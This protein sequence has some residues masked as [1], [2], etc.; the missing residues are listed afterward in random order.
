MTTRSRVGFT[1]IELLVVI[2]IIAILA[3]ILF[4]VFAQAREKA[5]AIACLSNTK[6]L[7]LAFVQYTQDWDEY[8][9]DVDKTPSY[10][11]LDGKLAFPPW[12]VQ[13]MPYV[14]SWQVFMCPDRSDLMNQASILKT[15]QVK[16][17]NG[18]DPYDCWD[19][20]NPTGECVGYGYNDGWVTDGGYGML[21]TQINDV[22][23]NTLRDGRNIAQIVSPASM[24]AFGDMKTK[25]DGSVGCDAALTWAYKGG[26]SGPQG[27]RPYPTSL[28]RHDAF[29]NF[30]FADGHA[31]S[32]KM[33]AA[34]ETSGYFSLANGGNTL[35]I[36]A[37]PQ[38]A[39]DWCF[40]PNFVANYNDPSIGGL[41]AGSYPLTNPQETC[42]QAINDVYYN[43]GLEV[44]Q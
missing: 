34:V 35:Q 14:K 19:D 28:L 36:P 43:Q 44:V 27:L 2:A 8:T 1:L 9:P 40:D 41:S 18:N 5:R 25:E 20:I 6:Q 16:K 39:Q 24:V 38:D 17:Y 7:A 26:P 15:K 29:E 31:H 22:H 30:V 21:K 33:V 23:G 37:N 42:T 4:P 11:G 10:P 3:A 12:Y 32:I 13:L